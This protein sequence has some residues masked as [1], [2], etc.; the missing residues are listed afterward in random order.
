MKKLRNIV[1]AIMIAVG[2]TV[3]WRLICQSTEINAVTLKAVD[4]DYT[5]NQ[6]VVAAIALNT[7]VYGC[8]RL[9]DPTGTVAEIIS[10]NEIGILQSNYDIVRTDPDDPS[11]A[12]FDAKDFVSKFIGNYRFLDEKKDEKS[13]FYAVSFADDTA[14]SVWIAFAGATDHRDIFSCAMIFLTPGLSAQEKAAFSFYQTVAESEEVSQQG[15]A[16][17]LTGHSLG[18]ILA[19]EISRVTDCQAVTINGADGIGMWKMNMIEGEKKSSKSIYNHLTSPK[20]GQIAA[21]D[22][23]Q[24]LMFIGPYQSV[25]SRI[26][27]ANGLTEDT[28]CVF[29]F[30][31]FEDDFFENPVIPDTKD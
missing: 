5:E 28:H 12:I 15:Y 2:F 1:I 6:E 7:V 19:T 8:E 3:G 21:L 24:H 25:N 13:G 30:I 14:K 16:V 27:N 18:G 31:Q 4:A 29:S 10:Y 9:D 17:I 23:V 20:N 22:A 26:Y 11:S